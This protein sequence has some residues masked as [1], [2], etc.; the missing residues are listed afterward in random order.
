ME[1]KTLNYDQEGEIGILTLNRPR[2]INAINVDM[3][4]E[5]N[6]FWTEMH[7]NFD[8]RVI[9]LKGAG[10]KGFCSG[11]DLNAAADFT[12]G[13]FGPESIYIN[14]RLFSSN[15]RLMRTCPQPIIS[16]MHGPVM[17]AGLAMACG[18][19]IRL[20]SDDSMFC[21]QYIN[22]GTGGADMGSSYFLWRMVGWGR[23]A[24]MCLT[25]ERVMAEE[26][27]KIGLINSI[28]TKDNLFK[29]A[30]DMAKTMVSKSKMGLRLTKEVLNGGLNLT[31]LEDATKMEDR[32][33][34][35][36]VMGGMMQTEM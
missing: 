13:D 30:I 26:A 3:L 10:E 1:Y 8:I 27:Y 33:Q 18:S 15:I 22:I 25:G 2:V 36:L 16:A 11:L 32:N 4:K 31:S 17:G 23:A 21:A 7:D 35:Y 14:Q 9:V 29:A 19:D 5:L 34:A 6:M 28:H 12:D 20:G 24:Q